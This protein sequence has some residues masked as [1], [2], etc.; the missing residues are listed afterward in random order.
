MPT[1]VAKSHNFIV[2]NSEAEFAAEKL[3]KQEMKNNS[4]T[5][6]KTDSNKDLNNYHHLSLSTSS[7]ISKNSQSNNQ[8][9][10]QSIN[11]L[12]NNI[13]INLNMSAQEM[14]KLIA[15]KRNVKAECK[16][17]PLDLKQKYEIIMQM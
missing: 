3:L 10:N 1:V 4:S 6:I 2:V 13:E 7:S 15:S 14:R 12:S 17:A 9:I 16:K 11:K 8:P 5:P